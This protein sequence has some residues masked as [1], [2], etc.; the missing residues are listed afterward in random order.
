MSDPQEQ[1]A[2][3]LELVNFDGQFA[4]HEEKRI[5]ESE[6]QRNGEEEDVG[7]KAE[8][9]V[10]REDENGIDVVPHQLDEI[11]ID[12]LGVPRCEFPWS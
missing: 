11:D 8:T 7:L 9:E 5:D 10:E 2:F 3:E 6:S 1:S 12:I 4:D